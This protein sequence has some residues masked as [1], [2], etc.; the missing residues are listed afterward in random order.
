MGHGVTKVNM[1]HMLTTLFFYLITCPSKY[2][3]GIVMGIGVALVHERVSP[4]R[5]R[6]LNSPHRKGDIV[7]GTPIVEYIVHK[8]IN[9]H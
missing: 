3:V 4:S 1:R 6:N 7:V 2:S 8:H 5:F 9:I